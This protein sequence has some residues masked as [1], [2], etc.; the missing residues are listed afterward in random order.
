M[1]LADY[2]HRHRLT[3][4][5]LR[6]DLG[7]R[8]RAT[9]LRYLTGERIPEPRILQKIID[10]TQGHVQ[11]TDFLS[12]D[13]PE[14]AV[15]VVLTCGSTRLVF[16]W[17][18]RNAELDASLFA[19]E[20]DDDSPSLALQKAVAIL[21]SRVQRRSSGMYVVDGRMTDVRGVIQA[22]N[23][24]LKLWGKPTIAYPGVANIA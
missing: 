11:L 24:L 16:P 8:S 9:V 6:R 15:R 22:A 3:P 13:L 12:D 1:K 14:C 10:I 7:V 23:R 18:N 4:S 19:D 2:L 17:T 5:T 21:G 20:E